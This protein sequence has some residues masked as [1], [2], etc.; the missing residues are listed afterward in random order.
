M[1]PVKVD[2]NGNAK[3]RAGDRATL[4]VSR[5]GGR[6]LEFVDATYFGF[7]PGVKEYGTFRGRGHLFASLGRYMEISFYLTNSL[8]MQDLN[9]GGCDSRCVDGISAYR[10]NIVLNFS[11]R[12]YVLSRL[13][14]NKFI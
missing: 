6:G 1:I 13:K 2:E 7:T 8:E 11:E 9:K 10:T 14:K 4:G 12:E 3:I 5:Q